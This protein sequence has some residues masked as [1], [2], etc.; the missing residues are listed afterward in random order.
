MTSL[1][2]AGTNT[3]H[4]TSPLAG[5]CTSLVVVAADTPAQAPIG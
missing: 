2:T 4:I 5:D 3:L 1:L